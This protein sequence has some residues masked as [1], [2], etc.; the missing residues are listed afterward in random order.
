MDQRPTFA[1]GDKVILDSTG[2]C[3]VVVHSWMSEELV[4]AEDCVVA[5]F[6]AAFPEPGRPPANKPYLLR[7]FTSS[8]RRAPR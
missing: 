1:A 8:L 2:E 7:Y 4:G 6:G 3:G 5:F